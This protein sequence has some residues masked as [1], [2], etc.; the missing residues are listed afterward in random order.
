MLLTTPTKQI[1][2]LSTVL[3]S[4]QHRVEQSLQFHEPPRNNPEAFGT[5][6]LKK[7]LTTQM[8][9]KPTAAKGAPVALYPVSL[10]VDTEVPTRLFALDPLVFL[11]GPFGECGRGIMSSTAAFGPKLIDLFPELGPPSGGVGECA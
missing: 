5:K 9:N 6:L 11:D 4:L 1:E 7:G 10:C 3:N 8:L 2:I